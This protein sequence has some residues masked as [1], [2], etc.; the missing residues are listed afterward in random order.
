M[1]F[2]H[3]KGFKKL[4][5][6]FQSDRISQELRNGLWDAFTTSFIQHV[7]LENYEYPKSDNSIAL[8]IQSFWHLYFKEPLDTIPNWGKTYTILRTHFFDADWHEAYDFIEFSAKH[9]SIIR[10]DYDYDLGEAEE[11]RIDLFIKNCNAVMERE[12]S[13]YR[14]VNKEIV[15]VTSPEEVASI[16]EASKSHFKSTN[17]HIQA[18]LALMADRKKPD[19]RNSIKESISAVEATCNSL[20]GDS[21]NTLGQALDELETKKIL[22]LHKA[23]KKAYQALYGY[24]SDAKGIRHAL[25]DE[26]SIDYDDAKFMLVSC[27]AFCNY[28]ISKAKNT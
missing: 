12:N 1:L 21:K 26:S 20:L 13:A 10:H 11:Y 22:T 14:F 9:Y 8:L 17:T 7:R 25:L 16:E 23:E 24:T 28:L 5:V 4:L 18:A 2:S 19:F 3:R 15:E 6:D 27:S